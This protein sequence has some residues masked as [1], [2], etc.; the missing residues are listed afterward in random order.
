MTQLCSNE[1][2]CG[3]FRCL[4]PWA[5]IVKTQTQKYIAYW[6]NDH[7]LADDPVMINP[8][9]HLLVRIFPFFIYL[10]DEVLVAAQLPAVYW[11][12]SPLNP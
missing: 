12:S 8:I 11:P 9:H 2:M 4:Q 3:N 6:I 10:V 5:K 7:P 1:L